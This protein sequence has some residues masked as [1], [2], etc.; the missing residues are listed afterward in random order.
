[1]E[2]PLNIKKVFYVAE[3]ISAGTSIFRAS[4]EGSTSKEG[5]AERR[6]GAGDGW[7][8]GQSRIRKGMYLQY[9]AGV[10]CDTPR[11]SSKMFGFPA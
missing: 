6:K 8:A 2:I 9:D 7:W 10:R 4:P 1:M 5:L 11:M 3:M